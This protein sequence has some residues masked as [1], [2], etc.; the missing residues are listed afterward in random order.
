MYNLIPPIKRKESKQD[1]KGSG[2]DNSIGLSSD[3]IKGVL[4]T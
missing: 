4:F 3:N 2:V 1:R